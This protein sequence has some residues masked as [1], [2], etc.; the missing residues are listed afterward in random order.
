MVKYGIF[1]NPNFQFG[2]AFGNNCGRFRDTTI[3]LGVDFHY[4]GDYKIDKEYLLWC[5][6]GCFLDFCAPVESIR[7][8]SILLVYFMDVPHSE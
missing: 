4:K 1:W 2:T 5:V 8:I 7:D 6:L 3:V